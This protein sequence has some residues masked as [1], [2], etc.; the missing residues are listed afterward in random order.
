MDYKRT[1]PEGASPRAR[2]FIIHKALHTMLHL[3]YTTFTNRIGL[4]A[5]TIGHVNALHVDLA[6]HGYHSNEIRSIGL[7]DS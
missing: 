3:L 6:G 1:S 5:V 4:V 2:A 7:A